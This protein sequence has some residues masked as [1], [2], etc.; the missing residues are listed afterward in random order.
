MIAAPL[1]EET[2][3]GPAH[4]F[5]IIRSHG[6]AG[7]LRIREAQPLVRIGLCWGVRPGI[8]LRVSSRGLAIRRGRSDLVHGGSAK[9]VVCKTFQL[10][11]AGFEWLDRP[12][13]QTLSS[14]G[15]SS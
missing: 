10:S 3:S 14:T 5:R 12:V 8:G 15:D 1:D 4:S 9:M 13:F 2:L 7:L 11:A 6:D